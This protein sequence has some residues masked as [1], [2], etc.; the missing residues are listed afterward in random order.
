MGPHPLTSTSHPATDPALCSACTDTPA[1]SNSAPISRGNRL[2]KPKT[3]GGRQFDQL[4]KGSVKGYPSTLR[5]SQLCA[6][7]VR[8]K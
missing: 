7:P 5:R 6:L 2:R 4:R 8:H 1:G 3:Y